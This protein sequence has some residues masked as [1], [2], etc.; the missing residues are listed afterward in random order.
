M[1]PLPSR[2]TESIV[3]GFLGKV[4]A[5]LDLRATIL[6]EYNKYKIGFAA[7]KGREE[8][9]ACFYPRAN[10]LLRPLPPVYD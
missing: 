8:V 5:F 1:R 10:V 7:G 9:P 4:V 2:L 3:S 6:P